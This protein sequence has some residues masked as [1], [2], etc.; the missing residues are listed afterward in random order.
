MLRFN[1]LPWREHCLR[2]QQRM[3]LL[4][5]IS[6]NGSLLLISVFLHLYFFNR[7][8]QLDAQVNFYRDKLAHLTMQQ[9]PADTHHPLR[10][11]S[12]FA[13]AAQLFFSLTKEPAQSLCFTEINRN[14]HRVS[15]EGQTESAALFTEYLKHFSQASLFS[16]IRIDHLE[17][18]RDGV[19]FR[20]QG[21]ENNADTL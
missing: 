13:T 9:I 3:G 14:N 4:L 11:V 10:S 12:S 8:N 1:L 21:I 16:E 6:I 2:Y 19:H 18:Q 7:I 5:F 15:F 17:H 20:F